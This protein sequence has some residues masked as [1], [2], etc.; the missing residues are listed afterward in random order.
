[1]AKLLTVLTCCVL[2]SLSVTAQSYLSLSTGISKDVNSNYNETFYHIP[3]TLQW[4]P[5]YS[6]YN[7]LFFEV[8]YALPISGN[9]TA[10]AY[11]LNPSLPPAVNLQEQVRPY[12]FTASIGMDWRI[13][14]DRARKDVLYLNF[15]TGVCNQT[16]TVKYKNYDKTNYEVLN[17]DVNSD[18]T[19]IVAIGEIVY[20]FHNNMI[21]MFRAQTPLLNEY[22]GPYTL[23]YKDVAP[24]QLTFGYSFYYN[25]SK[26]DIKKSKRRRYERYKRY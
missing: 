24:L 16:F 5:F 18:L 15:L 14:T 22:N 25:K 19:N 21:A 1:M 20:K 26:T 7:P 9:E 8:N 10:T 11:T 17:P 6:H 12:V 3:L 4:K 23:S 2:F 13:Y